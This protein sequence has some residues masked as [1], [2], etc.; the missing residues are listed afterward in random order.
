LEDS[1]VCNQQHAAALKVSVLACCCKP[2]HA[3]RQFHRST[4]DVYTAHRVQRILQAPQ[5]LYNAAAGGMSVLRLQ[6]QLL[7]I[8]HTLGLLPFCT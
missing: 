7:I 2:K 6:L 1:F 5:G 8:D 4:G 3:G